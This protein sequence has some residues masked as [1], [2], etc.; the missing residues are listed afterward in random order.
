MDRFFKKLIKNYFNSVA[1]AQPPS[2][3]N[4]TAMQSLSKR[5]VSVT[6]RRKERGKEKGS[7]RDRDSVIDKGRGKGRGNASGRERGSARPKDS[8]NPSP[9]RPPAPLEQHLGRWNAVRP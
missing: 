2:N 6:G 8:E 5:N 3:S 9:N 1:F 7:D 4:L